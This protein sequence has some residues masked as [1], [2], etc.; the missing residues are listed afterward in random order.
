MANLSNLIPDNVL[1]IVGDLAYQE[2]E[3]N[4]AQL[5]QQAQALNVKAV[6]AIADIV[7]ANLPKN[8]VFAL[9]SGPIGTAIKKA[10]PQLIAALGSEEQALYAAL[11][12]GVQKFATSHGG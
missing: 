2:L 1:G 12:A 5:L 10:E 9:L 4:K 11:E 6:D 7:V 8:G 3:A